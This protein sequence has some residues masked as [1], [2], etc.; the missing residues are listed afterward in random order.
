MQLRSRLNLLPGRWLLL[1]A[2]FM[3]PVGAQSVKPSML[4]LDGALAGST[5]VAVG[6]RGTAL[7]SLDR[8]VTWR[9]ATTPTRATLT[10]V[11]FPSLPLP[12]RGWA[13][14]HEAEILVSVDRGLTWSRQFQGQ[15]RTDSFLDVI[16]IDEQQA[17]AI[18]A[19]GLF[20]STADGG[21][22][23]TTR[24]IREE[25]SHLNRISASPAGTLYIAGEAGTLLKSTNK[26]STWRPIPSSYQGSF[27]GVLPLRERTLLAY[28]L[29]GHVY[30]SEDDGASWK[31]ITGAPPVLIA[32]ALSLPG[33]GIVLAGQARH[34]LASTDDGRSL[35]AATS[36]P[37]TAIAEL[38]DLG[39]GRVLA[40]GEAGAIDLKLP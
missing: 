16:A 36:A 26:G 17:I 4:L 8:G 21:A 5:L 19:Y 23:W 33:K 6:E 30:R 38:M 35:S 12:R 27:F 28:G 37:A 34:L 11:S 22:T 18:G 29:R 24:R 9:R 2:G 25:D 13:V 3:L 31:E 40:L 1:A 15:N 10:G 32:S 39:D 20:A 14:G 7:V